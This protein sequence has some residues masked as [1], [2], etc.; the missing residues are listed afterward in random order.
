M[1]PEAGVPVAAYRLYFIDGAGKF[2]AA[3]WIEADGDESA[4]A[5]AHGLNKSVKC[6]LWQG[7]RLI[8][9]IAPAPPTPGSDDPG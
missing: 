6:E 9:R 4:L 5:A 3:E 1:Y 2:T 8:A 7:R